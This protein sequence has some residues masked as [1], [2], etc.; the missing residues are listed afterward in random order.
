[1]ADR[2]S[3]AEVKDEADTSPR[4][5]TSDL[6]GERVRAIPAKGGTTIIVN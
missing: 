1:M 4:A 2:L 5:V 3:T 6:T